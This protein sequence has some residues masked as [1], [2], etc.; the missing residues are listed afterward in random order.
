MRRTVALLFGVLSALLPFSNTWSI[1][2][3]EEMVITPGLVA[4]RVTIARDD[5]HHLAW[6]MICIA[7]NGDLVCSY[8]VG[9]VH[10]GGAVP[11][12][13]VR[14]SKDLG[15]TWCDPVIVDTL[16]VSKGQGFMMCRWVSRLQNDSL[17]LAADWSQWRRQP[18]GTPHDWANDPQN[19]EGTRKAWLYRSIDNGRS[20]VGPEKT[21][22]MAVSLTMK[23]IGNGTLFLGGSHYRCGEKA[24]RQVLYRSVDNGKTW[25]EAITVLDDPRFS[26]VEGDLVE[27][28]GGTLVM[29]VRTDAPIAGAIK[30]I[31][32]DGGRTWKGPFAA[33]K[34]EINGRVFAS[35]LSTG[36]VFVVHRV[37]SDHFGFFVETLEAAL[38][39]VPYNTAMYKSPALN[40][41]IIDVEHYGPRPDGGYGGWVELPDGS[42]Y[43][44]NYIT[45]DAP[46]PQIRGYRLSRQVLLKAHP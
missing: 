12:A 30:M 10:G 36:E 4:E 24:W 15:R 26:A 35:R 16:Y 38:A 18:P 41:G 45:D 6:P 20:W 32:E 34:Y 27:M 44:V 7:P 1:S 3:A 40:W 14:I 5:K 9:D 25:S 21:N 23:Q 43:A 8:A 31:S 2:F 19:S 13:V 42:I 39:R 46:K 28:P 22:C 33:G 17:L 11:Q 37:G 29:Y